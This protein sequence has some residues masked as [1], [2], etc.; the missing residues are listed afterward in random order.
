MIDI[1]SVSGPALPFIH[2]RTH[3]Y[4]APVNRVTKTPTIFDPIHSFDYDIDKPLQPWI[5]LGW[6]DSFSSVSESLVAEIRAGAPATARLQVRQSLAATVAFNFTSRSK[7]SMALASGSQHLNVLASTVSPVLA[8]AGA[9]ANPAI[10]LMPNSGASSLHLADSSAEIL[11]GDYIVVDDD[12][13]TQTGFVGAGLSGA[14]VK[15]NSVK[16]VDYI[17]RVSF[18]VAQV[19]KVAGDG[20]LQLALPLIAGAPT[21][22]MK[23]QHVVG[24]A[25]REGGSFLQEWSGLFIR[26]GVQ[27]EKS[28]LYYPRLQSNHNSIE[29]SDSLGSD[30]T[31]V[32]LSARYRA[33]PIVDPYDG[34]QVLCY[35][36]FVPA[37][38][39]TK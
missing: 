16:D 37:P 21:T 20:A 11:A 29:S 19:V 24:F 36:S 8:G 2:Q 34:E 23:V 1:N 22:S 5:D 6:I 38:A 33:L 18:N 25:S 28:F 7:L 39:V 10:A 27:G 3:A 17:R 12:Y 14:Y 35:H 31:I 9:I 15:S 4:V 30:L 26:Y 32:K 13:A